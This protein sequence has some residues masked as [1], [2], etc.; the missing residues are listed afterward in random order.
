[1]AATAQL[2][3]RISAQIAEFQQAFKETTKV[4]VDFKGEFDKAKQSV[5]KTIKGLQDA[6][7]ALGTTAGQIG[8]AIVGIGAAIGAAVAA[9]ALLKA[10]VEATFGFLKSAVDDTIALGDSLYTL[11]KQ[12]GISVESLSGLKFAA[13]QSGASLETVT[14]AVNKMQLN[15]GKGSKETK[16][17]LKDLGLS[18]ADL[19]KQSPEAALAA[20]LGKLNEIDNASKRAAAGTAIFGKKW[21]EIA[22]LD[23]T[24]LK[25]A[26]ELVDEFGAKMSTETAVAADMLGDRIGEL[27]LQFEGFRQQIGA[28]LIPVLL[29]FVEV[30]GTI[31]SNAFKAVTKSAKEGGGSFDT[32]VEQIGKAAARFIEVMAI[33]VDAVAKWSKDTIIQYVDTSERVLGVMEKIVDAAKFVNDALGLDTSRFAGIKAAIDANQEALKGWRT[34]AEK[35][36][37][38]VRLFAQ[39]VEEAARTSGD[40][41]AAKYRETLAKIDKAAAEMR[42]KLAAGAAGGDVGTGEADE[43]TKAFAKSL[44]TL[45]R[46]I[47]IAQAAGTPFVELV[48]EWGDEASKVVPKAD[49]LGIAVA[50]LTRAVATGFNVA[51]LKKVEDELDAFFKKVQEGNK[52][53]LELQGLKEAEA[54]AKGLIKTLEDVG[55]ARERLADIGKSGTDLELQQIARRRKA[56]IDAIRAREVGESA[57]TEELVR[58][59][60]GYYD[61][62]ERV[63]LGTA[64]TIVERMNRQG[65]QTRAQL[66]KTAD[67]AVRDYRQMQASGEFTA[68]AIQA[69]FERMNAALRAAGRGT[70]I[71]WTARFKTLQADLKQIGLEA[72]Q[73]L[74]DAIGQGIETGDWSQIGAQL[75]DVLSD[76][77]AGAISAAVDFVVP[78]LG[79]ALKPLFKAITKKFLEMIPGLDRAGR[80]MVKAFAESMGGFDALRE[81]LRGLD[82]E[83]E[84][85]W[86][87]L[88]QR[89]RAGSEEQAQAAIDAINEAFERA[90]KGMK[91][92]VDGAMKRIK[93]FSDA[94]KT[95]SGESL[96][97]LKKLVDAELPELEI[98]IEEANARK[99]LEGFI[100]VLGG[101]REEIQAEFQR[102]GLYAGTAFAETLRD[103]GLAAALEA[104]GPMFDELN[105]LGSEFG[106]TLEGSAAKFAAFFQVAK[107]NQDV[108][109]ALEGL[110]QMIRGAG[111]AAF[112][113]QELFSAFGTD[114]VTQFTRLTERGVEVNQAMAL[115]QPTLQALWE[116]QQKFGFETDAATQALI[117]QGVA[118]GIV[119]EN[120]RD[121]N[122]RILD[123]L[124]AIAKVFNADLPAGLETTARAT[125]DATGRMKENFGDVDRAAKEAAEGT[126]RSWR[127]SV[128]GAAADTGNAAARMK[129]HFRDAEQAAKEAADQTGRHFRGGTDEAAE[130]AAEMQRKLAIQFQEAERAAAE[131]ARGID[132]AFRGKQYTVPIK[133]DVEDWQSWDLENPRRFDGVPRLGTGAIVRKPTLALVGESGPEIVAPLGTYFH[134]PRSDTTMILEI[135]GRMFA[136][137]V[138]PYLPGE[139][140]RIGVGLT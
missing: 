101:A 85:L 36:G 44:E 29:T 20:T 79:T 37:A 5:E 100:N 82:A 40:T 118:A 91:T 23:A 14:G 125:A 80:E 73:G 128:D 112:L 94:F 74:A 3:V 32:F 127:D 104:A 54:D 90:E 113:T 129:D 18:M 11:S 134:A 69:A 102:L 75:T 9:F 78:G 89:V 50:S 63:A 76:M 49:R 67:D 59:T 140:T 34:V 6:F 81:R 16:D 98:G 137:V 132:E 136:E 106:F 53:K 115:M 56:E 93:A 1:M 126:K 70:A 35:G 124:V 65:V 4:I 19:K 64:D 60:D 95:A 27:K 17:A 96:T 48:A 135:D 105:R 92:F 12:T 130:A 97:A 123:V 55:D 84:R 122:E 66:E 38:A 52:H 57:L 131:A 111:D 62:L 108:V 28:K 31:F 116:A 42:Q 33:M 119:G 30:F 114:A 2:A 107:E 8:L 47:A 22:Q 41:F 10:G 15:L 83:G 71:D 87:N 43:A 51:G 46:Q 103:Q 13:E 88:T 99:Q 77:F 121:V 72:V 7:K 25:E 138:A 120:Q 133:F 39:Q 26:I 68:E 109:G 21:Q 61:H 24:E 86:I 110:E 117:D 139:V 58:L 45:S